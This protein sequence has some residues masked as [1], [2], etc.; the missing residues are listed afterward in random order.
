MSGFSSENDSYYGSNHYSIQI[1]SQQFT[2]TYNGVATTGWEQ[3]VFR[4]TPGS[5]GTVFIEY[6]LVDF[7][8]DHG[9]CPSGYVPGTTN[10]SW[11]NYQNTDCWGDSNYTNTPVENPSN[12]NNYHFGGYANFLSSGN[13]VATFCLTGGSCYSV[14]MPDTTLSLYQNWQV[15]EVNVFGY[16]DGYQA[17]FNSGTYINITVTMATGSNTWFTPG[18]VYT[19]YS[20]ETNNLNLGS[21]SPVYG[22]YSFNESL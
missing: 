8:N 6:W 2:T 15:S 4:N 19:S 5:G 21:F 18:S 13:D 16:G 11:N 3:F 9:F 12:L 7:Y 17:N 1:N 22:Q 20:A 10:H 14:S